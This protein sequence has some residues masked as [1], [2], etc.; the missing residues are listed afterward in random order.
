M[1]LSSIRARSRAALAAATTILTATALVAC[2][3]GAPFSG[4]PVPAT[5][6]P[7]TAPSGLESFYQQ[8]VSWYPCPKDDGMTQGGSGSG[9]GSYSCARVTVPLDYDDPGGA[10]IEITLK[11]RAADGTSIGQLFVNPGGPGG[12]GVS[13]AESATDHFSSQL[14]KSYDV[15]GF[16][17]RG[18]GNSTA[19]DCFTDAEMDARRS[20][21]EDTHGGAV[22]DSDTASPDDVRAAAE[23]EGAAFARACETSTSTPGLLDHV[24]TVSAAR[25]LDILRAVVTGDGQLNY[26]GYSYGTYLG[27]TY[28]DLFPTNVGRMLLDG[29]VDPTLTAGEVSLGQAQGFETALRTYVADCQAGK[30]CPL[31]GDPDE[32]VRQVREFLNRT[33]TVPVP[34]SSPDRPLTYGLARDALLGL[35]YQSE[36]WS[37]LTEGLSQAMNKDDG[38]TLL[39]V[40]DLFASRNDDGTYD[41][42]SNEVIN[43][44]NCLDYPVVGDAT[45]WDAEAEQIEA[46]SPTF[47]DALTYSDLFCQGWGHTSS[48]EREPVRATGSAPILVVGT[49]GDPATP[50]AWA[51][52]LASQLENGHLLTWDGTGHTAYGRGGR[53]VTGAVDAYL[54]AGELP[55][56]GLVCGVK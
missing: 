47:G 1:S 26:L 34:T 29:A 11:R 42:N 28:A 45:S 54:L 41:D 55:E 6:Q 4:D 21:D 52:A 50:L 38:S 18:V 25:D 24:D 7:A 31:S 46:A 36:S 51:R 39:Y 20:G 10:T 17:P 32:G 43:A 30:D 35:M 5:G 15:V 33:R 19:V 23:E 48:R 56:D 16:D 12:S 40:A 8:T 53:C 3:S 22:A 2:S 13:L 27:S 9:P 14:V 44:V 37:I 49:S